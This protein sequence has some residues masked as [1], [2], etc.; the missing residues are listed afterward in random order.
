[1][2]FPFVTSVSF[3]LIADIDSPRG[4]VIRIEPKNLITLK[5]ALNK[6]KGT[7]NQSTSVK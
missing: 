4:G 7:S 2:I 5:E 3:F 1:M 6:T